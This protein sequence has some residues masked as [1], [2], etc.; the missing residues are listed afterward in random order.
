ML[1]LLWPWFKRATKQCVTLQCCLY[2]LLP[3][4]GDPDNFPSCQMAQLARG[5]VSAG[6]TE[7]ERE[8]GGCSAV[9]KT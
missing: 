2:M 6:G 4:G 7:G 1:L 9:H 3:E 8:G 5:Q